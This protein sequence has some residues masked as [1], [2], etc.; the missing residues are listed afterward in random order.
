M[1]VKDGEGAT[2]LVEIE[3]KNAKTEEDAKKCA[4]KIANS[5]LVKTMFFGADPNWGRLLAS[6]GASLIE[7][8][9]DNIDIYFNKL[10]YVSKSTIID[11]NIE[12]KA[13]EIM[14]NNEYKITIDLNVGKKSFSVYTCDLTYEYVKINTDYRT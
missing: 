12:N 8:D 14:K 1:I 4:F 9:P 11:V 13:H 5:P 3:I 10:H 7:I 6:V 2:K